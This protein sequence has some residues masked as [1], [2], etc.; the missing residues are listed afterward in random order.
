MTRFHLR[1]GASAATKGL[2][3]KSLHCAG[4]CEY[5]IV[6]WQFGIPATLAI[7][8]LV[9]VVG[10]RLIERIAFLRKYSIPEPVVGGL[11]TAVLITVL[12][13]GGVRLHVRH[14]DATRT[15]ARLL[16]HHRAG[17]R[18]AHAG[19]RRC[20]TA[21]VHRLCRWHA[22][23]AE[24][25]RRRRGLGHGHRSADRVDRRVGHDVGRA[26]YRR[27]MGPDVRRE[28][29]SRPPRPALRSLR[30]PSAW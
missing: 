19:A 20:R 17:R 14:V 28:L 1:A 24:R 18:R 12:H 7:A 26:R 13:V 4:M 8:A 23:H 3:S 22:G 5:L 10:R 15:D 6:D 29:R 2:R 25:H 11:L 9:L 27:G 30:P 16:R 21:A